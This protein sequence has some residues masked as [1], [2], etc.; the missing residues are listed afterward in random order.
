MKLK[1]WHFGYG[2]NKFYLVKDVCDSYDDSKSGKA[3]NEDNHWIWSNQLEKSME[4]LEEGR[5]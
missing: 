1:I 5:W 3:L 2:S 4:K